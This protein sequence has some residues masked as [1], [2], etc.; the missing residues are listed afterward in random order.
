MD[1]APITIGEG[2]MFSRGNIVITGT[3]DLKDIKTII[4]RPVTIG[5]NCWIT[6][7][8]IILPGVTIGD[9]C[10]IGAGSVV[11]ID[12]PSNSIVMGNPAKVVGK[13]QKN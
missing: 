7:R 11:N 4:A 6:T 2:T 13:V 3:H 9:N 10:V 12:I 5:N 1:Y 8:C